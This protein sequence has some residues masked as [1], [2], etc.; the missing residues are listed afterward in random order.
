MQSHAPQQPQSRQPEFL[1]QLGLSYPC[2]EQDVE[3]AYRARVW[4]VHPDRGGDADGFIQLQ[5]AY[6]Q[7]LEYV[8]FHS[9]KTRWLARCVERYVAQGELIAEIERNGGRARIVSLDWLAAEIGEDFAQV[10]DQIAG[11][12]L[13]GPTVGDEMLERL[14]GARAILPE[15]R[16]L[17]LKGSRVTD[18]GVLRLAELA[19]L[20][21]LCLAGTSVSQRALAVLDGLT[22][23]KQLDL[24]GTRVGLWGRIRLACW[25]PYLLVRYGGGAYRRASLTL[26]RGAAVLS[27]IW[28]ATMFALTHL[29]PPQVPVHVPG[30]L[31]KLLHGAMYVVLALLTSGTLALASPRPRRLAASGIG[32]RQL[33]HCGVLAAWA[34]FDE[35][36]QRF[37]GRSFEWSDFAADVAGILAGLLLAQI[38]A[39]ALAHW[40]PGLWRLS[41]AEETTIGS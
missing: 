2:V 30:G 37:A 4:A 29:P 28:L 34:Y 35:S 13:R 21:E 33:L 25:R 18:A 23:L 24:S 36:T 6:E 41:T 8:R 39:G 14:A 40:A 38:A 3:E 12:E 11:I 1:K 15:L 26:F 16:V 17:D 31:D 19:S 9:G 27:A 20:H 22:E 10:M 5:R 7:A 32:W